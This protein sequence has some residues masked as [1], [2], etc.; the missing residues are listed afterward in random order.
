ME[1]LSHKI[2]TAVAERQWNPIRLTKQ[3]PAISH[4]FF[5]DDLLLFG[6]ISYSQGRMMEF[7]LNSFCHESGQKVSRSKSQIWFSP[8]TPNYLRAAICHSFGVMAT[9]SLGK[10]LG[11]P[12]TPSR[13]STMLYQFL[14]DH[15]RTRLATWK[16]KTLS[17][18]ARTL[19]TQTTLGAGPVYV[20]QST[21][22]PITILNRLD[23]I[24]RQFIWGDT[25]GERR[26]HTVNWK[27]VCRG[28]AEGGLGIP[29]LREVN[30]AFMVKLGWR[31]TSR[32][33][34][35]G[36]KI[37]QT[38]YGGWSALHDPHRRMAASKTWRS[39]Q[40]MSEIIRKVFG[41]DWDVATGFCSGRTAG[42]IR[43]L[44]YPLP[45]RWCPRLTKLNGFAITGE[46]A[47]AG[48]GRSFTID[49][50]PQ[51][52]GIYRRSNVGC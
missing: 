34:L 18:A 39:L 49:S 47:V 40:V 22:L 19:L 42:L 30:Q 24:N 43:N 45:L 29:D 23:R 14:V 35:L 41:G 38:K 8:K 2:D 9:A 46:R 6:E 20:M 52:C 25:D 32:T 12:M 11:V 51:R 4:L 16:M 44:S 26:M 21:S 48:C 3:G 31:Y 50:P 13:S 28:K 27:K 7:I 10:Y 33:D 15:A 36:S 37:L 1:V 5:A 17:R